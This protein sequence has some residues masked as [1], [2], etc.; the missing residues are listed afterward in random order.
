MRV[1]I[2]S[3]GIP[4]RTRIIDVETGKPVNLPITSVVWSV[5]SKDQMALAQIE[6]ELMSIDAEADAHVSIFDRAS[7][8]WRRVK[9]IQFADGSE[10]AF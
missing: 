1:K 7:G 3:D 10:Q 9:S 8:T 5:K 2:V 6:I 4:N